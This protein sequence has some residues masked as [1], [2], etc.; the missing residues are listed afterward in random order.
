MKFCT[1][2]HFDAQLR[3][4]ITNVQLSPI[5]KSSLRVI[6]SKPWEE[7]QG[8]LV[9]YVFEH[10]WSVELEIIQSRNIIGDGRYRRVREISPEKMWPG[11]ANFCNNVKT[12]SWHD[13]AKSK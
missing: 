9:V 6:L 2:C 7:R 1:Y 5:P 12:F 10:S 3:V 13:T 4:Q 11:F 8:R